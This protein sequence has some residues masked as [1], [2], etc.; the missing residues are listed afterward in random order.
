M[1]RSSSEKRHCYKSIS[2]KQLAHNV[3]EL[4]E[5]V[6]MEARDDVLSPV[7]LELER[8]E[9]LVYTKWLA[10]FRMAYY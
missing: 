7:K 4:L 8:L 9:E 6:T 3:E 5:M 10:A 1:L 2:K